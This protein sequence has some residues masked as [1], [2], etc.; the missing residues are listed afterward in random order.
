MK[1]GPY[2]VLAELGR[3]GMGVVFRV[4]APGGGEAALKLLG[5]V[6]QWALVRFEREKR[7]LALLGEEHG[8]VPL[9]DAG[10]SGKGA[11]L[12]MPLVPGGTLRR[13]LDDGPLAVEET[14]AL[15]VRLATALGAAHERGIIHRDVKPENVLFTREGVPLVAD[16]GLAKHF[17]TGARGATQSV[18]L[19]VD[20]APKGT[21]GYMAPEQVEDFATVGPPADVYSLGAVLYECLAG[22]PAFEG[23]NVLE[24]LTKVASGTVEP[25][26]RPGVP[27]WLEEVVL[28][29]LARDPSRR[30]ADGG[31]LARALGGSAKPAAR[32][33]RLV[34]LLAALLVGIIALALEAPRFRARQLLERG[35]GKRRA[36]DLDGAI[37]D[38]DRA[39]DLAPGLAAAWDERSAAR[40]G[41]GEVDG[42]IDDAAKAIELDPD[43]ALAWGSRGAARCARGDLEG[44]IADETKALD[45]DPGL[46]FA[47]C[48]RGSARVTKGDLDGAIADETRAIELDATLSAAWVNRGSARC[49]KGDLDGALADEARA[50]ELDPGLAGAW[51]LHGSARIQK[52]ELD[53]AIDDETRAIALDGKLAKAWL[54]RGN[55]RVTRDPDGAIAD[56]TRAIE[57]DPG[58]ANAWVIRANAHFKKDELDDAIAD[59]TRAIALDSRLAN[60]WVNRGMA[61]IKR[62]DL[63]AAI[64]DLTRAIELVPALVPAW[65]NR[66][67]ARLLKKEDLGAAIADLTRAIELEPR[68]AMAWGNR[69]NARRMA[70]DLD[71]AIADFETFLELDPG[72]AQAGAVRKDVAE[73][74]AKRAR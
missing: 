40:Y 61:R 53:G 62:G 14:V 12:V 20:G 19:T 26:A 58:L 72:N 50:I 51:L 68:N 41:K 3:G 23:K 46:T 57:L 70:G 11:W 67:T 60:A 21:V 13:R 43:F 37:Q 64:D 4:R 59:A 8:F 2:D 5:D 63:D 56:E 28:R 49:Q 39:I 6:D 30:F 15:G 29:A 10:S 45:L 35:H 54:T 18:R 34:P 47:W 73:L 32:R 55:A 9:L 42:A 31:S 16:L 74:K 24:L 27:A 66:G 1:I 71:G 25:I 36:G 17:D 7:L 69:A 33:A 44:A 48:N 52:G 22:R 65:L 38:L